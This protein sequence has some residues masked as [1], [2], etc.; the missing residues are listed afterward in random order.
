MAPSRLNDGRVVDAIVKERAARRRDDF[1]TRMAGTRFHCDLKHNSEFVIS[2][3][4]LSGKPPTL[5]SMLPCE[6]S[7][8]RMWRQSLEAES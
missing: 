1:H 2:G 7:R 5:R 8:Q 3:F 4:I 6:S